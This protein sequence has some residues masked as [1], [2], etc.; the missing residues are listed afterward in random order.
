MLKAQ[1]LGPAAVSLTFVSKHHGFSGKMPYVNACACF[2]VAVRLARRVH[3]LEQG[4]ATATI[5]AHG[6]TFHAFTKFQVRGLAKGRRAFAPGGRSIL[7]TWVAD[8]RP[9]PSEREHYCA[10]VHTVDHL[11]VKGLEVRFRVLY[12]GKTVSWRAG[13]TPSSGVVCSHKSIGKP[14]PG[15][16]VKVYAYAGKL[17][18]KTDFQPR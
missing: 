7:T 18:A 5:K 1:K 9:R 6:K 2:R 14:H 16:K 8:P 3:S 4:R 11:G 12:P 13:K 15:S 17:H 10:W